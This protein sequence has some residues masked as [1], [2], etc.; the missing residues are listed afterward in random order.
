LGLA[1]AQK[2]AEQLQGKIEVESYNGW[3][4]FTVTFPTKPDGELV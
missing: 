3:T 4:T 2:L 1:L